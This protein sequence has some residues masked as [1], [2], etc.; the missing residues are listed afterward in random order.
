[1]QRNAGGA[2]AAILTGRRA[3]RRAEWRLALQA[4]PSSDGGLPGARLKGRG[5][6]GLNEAAA[7]RSDSPSPRP[8]KSI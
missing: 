7:G 2:P 5:N 6:R 3:S 1:M 4:K 8:L